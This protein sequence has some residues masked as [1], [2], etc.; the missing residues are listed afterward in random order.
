MSIQI[1][2]KSPYNSWHFINRNSKRYPVLQEYRKHVEERAAEGIP[3]KPLTA[4]QVA[5]LVELLKPTS[6]RRRLPSR[7][8]V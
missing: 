7:A 1:C 6:G 8:S 4:E 2:N 5:D 3:P